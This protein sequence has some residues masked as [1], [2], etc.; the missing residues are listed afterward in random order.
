MEQCWAASRRDRYGSKQL[1]S[2]L[3][4]NRRKGRGCW[5]VQSQKSLVIDSS[6]ASK[7]LPQHLAIW[8]VGHMPVERFWLELTTTHAVH[9]DWS[10][11][12]EYDRN[13]L[14]HPVYLSTVHVR[15]CLRSC[16]SD[17]YRGNVIDPE[18]IKGSC[19][20]SHN[21]IQERISQIKN[22]NFRNMSYKWWPN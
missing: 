22:L 21:C 20:K 9:S 18:R 14:S 1:A 2:H 5:Q 13:V 6:I 11:H 12:W 17:R 10:K 7:T 3:R 16:C 4:D 19:K 8:L 15:Q